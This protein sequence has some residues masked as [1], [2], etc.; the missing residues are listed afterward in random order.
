[1]KKGGGGGDALLGAFG[2]LKKFP[3]SRETSHK[4]SRMIKTKINFRFVVIN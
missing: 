3:T 2:V 1:M 4:K